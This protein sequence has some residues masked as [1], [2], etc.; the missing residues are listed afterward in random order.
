MRGQGHGPNLLEPGRSTPDPRP[1]E[2]LR[3]A[4]AAPIDEAAPDPPGHDPDEDAPTGIT[5]RNGIWVL[6]IGGVWR[7][8]YRTR[9]QA[10]AAAERARQDRE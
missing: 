1:L 2:N 4:F 10:E 3:M 8:D 9:E 5:E 7:G 6:T